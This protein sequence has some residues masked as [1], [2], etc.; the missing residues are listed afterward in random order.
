MRDG[1]PRAIAGT[2]VG[3]V[4]RPATVA[5][6]CDVLRDAHARRDTVSF[7]GGGTE[8]GLGY[9]P[10]RVDVLL[11]THRLARV[12]DYAP[13][14]LVIEVEAGMTLAALRAATL[15]Q[16]QRFVLD[17][18]LPER[19]TVGGVV[20]TNAFGPRRTR[21]GTVRDHIVGGSLIRADGRL[22][23]GGGKVVKNVAGFDLPKLAVGSLGT[24]AL[25]ARVTLRLHPLPEASAALA[26]A[27]CSNDDLRALERGIVA[28]Q[29]EPSAFVAE[30]TGPGEHRAVVLFE[31]FAAGVDEQRERLAAF[32]RSLSRSAERV[33]PEVI[34][35]IDG[36][37]RTHGDVRM[38]CCVLPSFARQLDRDGLGPLYAALAE[39][40][41]VAYPSLGIVFVSGRVD[42]C[43]A[44][45]AALLRARTAAESCGGN[46]VLL[47]ANDDVRARIDPY[48]ATPASLGLMREL[49]ARFDPP[50]RLNPGRFIGRI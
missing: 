32:A 14:D 44:V 6:A 23:R 46:A 38:R 27:G 40:R 26:I 49:K 8:L 45:A 39:A 9:P 31:G 43:D 41:S 25:I 10:E 28:A 33:E 4:A 12:V 11:A 34:E 24:L 7:Y 42:D 18:P 16:R 13:A 2:P 35:R 15:A 19:A 48:G 36:A 5:E 1:V 20:A 30:R 50:R 37:T 22:V 3:M 29:L 47:E 17:C 21:F